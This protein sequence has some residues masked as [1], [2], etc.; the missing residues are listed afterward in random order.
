MFMCVVYYTNSF[1]F[2]QFSCQYF[3][4]L[5]LALHLSVGVHFL[6]FG[7]SRGM[8]RAGHV[9]RWYWVSSVSLQRGHLAVFNP[10]LYFTLIMWLLHLNSSLFSLI[11]KLLSALRYG[12]R[13]KEQYFSDFILLLLSLSVWSWIKAASFI[14]LLSSSR[15]ASCPRFIIFSYEIWPNPIDCKSSFTTLHQSFFRGLFTCAQK[16]RDI[17][18]SFLLVRMWCK[19]MTLLIFITNLMGTHPVSRYKKAIGVDVGTWKIRR[20]KLW[21]IF[22]SRFISP[23]VSRSQVSELVRRTWCSIACLII[24]AAL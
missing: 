24:K 8:T 5:A 19:Y 7:C 15:S 23:C 10:K 17:K 11:D 21:S 14:F 4:F 1:I 12:C 16:A 3:S 18:A 20:I 2:H 9:S 13:A 22:S 6:H